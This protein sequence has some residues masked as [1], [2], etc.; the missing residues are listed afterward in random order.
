MNE[1]LQNP[2]VQSGVAPFVAA[3]IVAIPLRRSRFMGI[4]QVAGFLTVAALA[5]GFSFESLTSTKKLVLLGAGTALVV[6]VLELHREA[7]L[8]LRERLLMVLLIGASCVWMLW[9]LLAQMQAP[10]AMLASVLAIAYVSA[11]VD[12][13]LLVSNDPV[14]GAATGLMVGLGTGALAVLGASAVLGLIGIAVGASAGATLLVQMVTG[15]PARL[16]LTIALPACSIA[17]FVGVLAVMGASLPWFCLLPLLASPWA[18]RLVPTNSRP[19]WQSAFLTALAALV[20]L[21]AA[22]GLAWFAAGPSAN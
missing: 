2:A 10:A 15:R 18:T 4:A 17:G 9:R 21:L 6:A 3:L 7:A 20:P 5:I 12:S 16:G 1:L 13:T 19:V 11:L 8:G 22:V 14:R